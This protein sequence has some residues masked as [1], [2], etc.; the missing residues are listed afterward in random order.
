MSYAAFFFCLSYKKI[1]LWLLYVQRTLELVAYSQM[2][3]ETITRAKG[4]ICVGGD[5]SQSKEDISDMW[6][7]VVGKI[8]DCLTF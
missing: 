7:E 1:F 4:E 2:S 8:G 5:E 3:G 6:D